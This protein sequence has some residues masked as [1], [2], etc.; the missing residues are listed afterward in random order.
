MERFVDAGPHV[1]LW[2]ESRG[3]PAAP[4]LLLIMGANAAGLGWPEPF[5][6]RLAEHH[7]VIRYDHRDTGRSTWA[8]DEHP[9]AVADLA[10]DAVTVLDALGVE[11]CHA[12]GMSMGGVLA[13]LLL[14]D[15]PHR[16]RTATIFGTG[17]LGGWTLP[18]GEPDPAA[19]ELPGIAPE[20]LAIWERMADPRDPEAEIAWRVEH[21][22]VLNGTELAFDPEE[23]RELERR[24]IDHAGTHRTPTA[25][26]RMG[27]TGL[28]RGP[29]LAGVRTPTLVIE[30][31]A[32][33]A[34]P[35]PHA[36]FLA[37]RLPGARLV[38]V[39][40]MGHA[41]NS[42]ILPPLADAVL[43][44]TTAPATAAQRPRG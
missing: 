10:T 20:L 18:D 6:D 34:Y 16:L 22:R 27:L 17:A 11:R 33:P 13:Q 32:D 28:D 3:D 15:H 23:F 38:T 25:H 1:R 26:A 37:G 21:W 8:F 41:L 5:V 14:L 7:H 9:Y 43:A 2:V 19:A 40:G 4:A 42:R 29:E 30:A 44:H 35:P 36:R 12:V 31:P 39:P 24:V